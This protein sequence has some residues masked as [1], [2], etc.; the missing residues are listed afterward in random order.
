M[1]YLVIERRIH[2]NTIED[3]REDVKRRED[4]RVTALSVT[5]LIE[6]EGDEMWS[7][8]LIKDLGPWLMLQL[9]DLANSFES[10]RKFVFMAYI[11]SEDRADTMPVS[12]SGVCHIVLYDYSFFS[13]SVSLQQQSPRSGY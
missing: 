13:L 7:D 5:E 6:K 1:M 3:L 11:R 2:G 4:Q 9:S 12:M 8:E 10:M